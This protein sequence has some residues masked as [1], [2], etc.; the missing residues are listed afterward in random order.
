MTVV[1]AIAALALVLAIHGHAYI[2]SAMIPDQPE[3]TRKT[4]VTRANR[5]FI[6]A[7]WIAVIGLVLAFAFVAYI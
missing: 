5:C 2:L 4:M 7:F 6:V 1:V 3:G